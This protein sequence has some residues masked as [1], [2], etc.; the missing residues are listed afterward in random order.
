[1]AR[2]GEGGAGGGGVSPHTASPLLLLGRSKA[3]S[4]QLWRPRSTSV[5]DR[6]SSKGQGGRTSSLDSES[7][8]DSWH[9]TQVRPWKP[10]HPQVFRPRALLGPLLSA[11]RPGQPAE[12]NSGGDAVLGAPK[13][14][15]RS[16]EPD[17]GLRRAPPR[18]HR[19]GERRR[20]AGAGRCEGTGGFSRPGQG[21]LG[22]PVPAGPSSPPRH[23]PSWGTRCI[24]SAELRAQVCPSTSSIAAGSPKHSTRSSPSRDA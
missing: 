20:V 4:K 1:M 14:C 15:L 21:V 6:Q 5:K 8:P 11:G 16:A 9:S 12:P 3:E 18:E 10:P 7:S 19:A 17:P 22:N 13:V 2:W 23:G 24:C